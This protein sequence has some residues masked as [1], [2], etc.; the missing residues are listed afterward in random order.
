MTVAGVMSGTS[1]DGIDVALVRINPGPGKPRMKLLAH[2]AVGYPAALRRAVLDAM[3]A[4]AT[5]TAE[6]ARLNWRLGMAYAEAV[7]AAVEKYRVKIGL[8]G[9][10]GQTVYHQGKAEAY[11]GRKVACTWQ[12]G[13]P[14]LIAAEMRVPV[15]SNFRPADMAAGGQGAP[16]VPLL[17]YVLFA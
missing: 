8:V 17:D 12:V 3:D 9:C 5:S 16:L 15:V 10:H 4:K 14:A 7:R 6:L 2:H 13:E 1:A 11:A